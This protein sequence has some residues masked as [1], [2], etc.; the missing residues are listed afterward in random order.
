MIKMMDA[1]NSE[2]EL[3]PGLCQ[4]KRKKSRAGTSLDGA[5]LA[6]DNDASLVGE[7]LLCLVKPVP[8]GR[9]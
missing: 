2:L 8:D 9:K 3:P 7:G 1:A 6:N 4:K 5:S